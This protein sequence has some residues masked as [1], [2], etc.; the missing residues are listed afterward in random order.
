MAHWKTC[1]PRHVVL[2]WLVVTFLLLLLL[3]KSGVFERLRETPYKYYSYPPEINVKHLLRSLKTGSEPAYRVQNYYERY[4]FKIHNELKCR[5]PRNRLFILIVVKSAIAHQSSRDTIRQTWGQE[6]RFEDVS[7]RRVFI[8]GVKA[9]DETAQRALEDEHALHGDLVQADF[10]DSYY[11]NTFKTMLAFRWVLEHCFNVQWVF[12]VDDDSYVSAKNLVQF[13][14]NSM[15]WTDRHL[16]G[17]IHDDAPPYRAHWSKWYVSLSEYPYSRYPPFAVGCLYV[18]SMPAL[19]ELYQVARYTRQYRFDDV[20]LGIV[21][22][23]SG[24]RPRHSDKFRDKNPA[25]RPEDFV[26]LV[27]S[28]G[29]RDSDHLT[30]V[31]EH[32]KR[33]GH[34]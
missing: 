21:A 4:V 27:A 19:M 2:L 33:L 16:V 9:N 32:Q 13:L 31:W 14:R 6:D 34:A 5:V 24:L 22:R 30:R 29:F 11:N 10:I 8:V 25:K 23:K 20:F 28:H 26:G 18:V 12:F 1:R 7:L 15:N 17:Y 3:D